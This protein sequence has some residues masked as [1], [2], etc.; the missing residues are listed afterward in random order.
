MGMKRRE[1]IQNGL[2]F[3]SLGLGMPGFLA[4]TAGAAENFTM[5][6]A[7]AG[8]G[9]L[10][11]PIPSGK[12]LVVIEMAGGNDGLNTVVPYTQAAY[13]KL[14]PSIGVAANEVVKM[15][16]D[17]GLN[18]A[19]GALGKLYE[20]GQL[21]VL[22]GVGY[23]NPNRSHFQ[24]MDIWQTG[25]PAISHTDRT[26]WLARY[27]DKEGH[28]QGNPLS[29]V[30]LGGA[31]P[32]A[33]DSPSSP[34]SVIGNGQ[35]YGFAREGKRE[36]DTFRSL[37]GGPTGGTVAR[38][39]A[40]FI[41]NV[42]TQ[43][44]TSTVAI[45]QALQAY[46]ARGG[47]KAAYPGNNGLAGSLQTI[48]KLITGGLGTRIYYCSLGGFDT[49]ANQPRQH[50]QL[51]GYL[52]DSIA[53]FLRD[54]GLHGREKDVAVMTFSE[55][56]RRVQENGSSGTDHGA[57]SV[58]FVAGAGIKGGVYGDYPSLT[59]L[60]DGDLR[61]HTDFRRVYATVLDRWLGSPSDV[62]LDGK[63]APLA[64]V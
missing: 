53:A 13:A 7:E 49:H 61:F 51:L 59:D 2:A 36:G 56:G 27:F 31:L 5:T 25:R 20:Q 26:G 6:G 63:F 28:Y 8:A 3:V 64:F 19:M 57:A 35:N 32:L 42:G 45:K 29:G 39:N 33:L 46:D 18:P 9:A 4:R 23:P 12:I 52:S 15:G 55:F 34:V 37:Y 58:M 48:A 16:H 10:L 22:N 62:I 1:F 38:N 43:V 40:D 11:P 41:R 30:V 54:M 44:Y 60:D 24:S 21:A 50:A 47:E 14:R 17:I